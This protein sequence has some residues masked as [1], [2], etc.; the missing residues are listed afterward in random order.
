MKKLFISLLAFCFVTLSLFADVTF[1]GKAPKAVVEG[2]QF[3]VEFVLSD[4]GSDFRCDIKSSGLR[5]LA[6][7]AVSTGMSMTMNQGKRTTSMTSTYTYY[8]MAEK[9]GKYTIPAASV[10][11]GSQVY[12]S[13]P[14]SLNVLPPD[15]P[16]SSG[17]SSG[18]AAPN[19]G[20]QSKG[21]S[22]DDVR[23]NVDLSKTKVYEG[24]AILATVKLYFR[25]TDIEYLS[26]AKLPD[27][28]GF[29]V[30]D[31][32]NDNPQAT[33]E[34]FNDI[35]YR[36]YPVKQYLLFPQR[37]GTIEIPS[38]SVVA[39]AQVVTTRR[40][41]GFFDM[42][43]DFVQNVEIPVS[44][45]AR[46]VTVLPLPS[47][48]PASF[49]GA[50]GRFDVKATLS[51]GQ[52]K[53]NDAITYK[54]VIE[55][56]GN[57]KYV[58]SPEIEFPSDFEVYDPKVDVSAKNTVQGV[59]GKKVLEYTIIPRHA[60][61]FTIPALEFSYFDPRSEQYKTIKTDSFS[62]TVEKGDGDENASGGGVADFTGPHQER[63]KVLGSDIRYIRDIDVTDL[64]LGY[65][66]FYGTHIYYL[67]LIIP[68]LLFIV[69]ALIYRRQLKLNADLSR[70]RR[71]KANKVASKR[72][73]EAAIALKEKNPAR[74]YE[75]IH[76]AMLGYVSDKLSIPMGELSR[77]SVEQQ[78]VSHGASEEL[79][80]EFVDVL[81]TCEFARYAPSS[82]HRAMDTLYER[83][84]KIIGNLDGQLKKR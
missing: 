18:S 75:A 73:K 71:G 11:V 31:I 68:Q 80:H 55:G 52:V 7:P 82:D 30:Q 76:K 74:F 77:E 63:L 62:I 14:I 78:L 50:V 13:Q 36:M 84:G 6:G 8:L 66:P 16:A 44:S 21:I 48:K 12:T 54:L 58:K 56:V 27:F 2:Q 83:A 72:L 79:A 22:K 57:L 9:E 24:E 19:N 17:N 39:V 65:N 29:T 81:S 3:R 49:M 42:P 61:D 25:N 47:G 45:S 4:N 34:R 40:T 64:Q 5:V 20:S 35:N 60:G 59:S 43:M 15:K 33:L 32:E 67:L 53:V 46:K 70:K 38:A 41:G 10:K 1:V 51:S 28:A 69:I 37:N 23:L 26:E